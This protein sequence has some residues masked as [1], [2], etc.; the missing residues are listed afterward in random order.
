MHPGAIP[1]SARYL[2]HVDKEGNQLYRVT[3]MKSQIVDFIKVMKKNGFTC[4]D[5]FYDLA[6]Y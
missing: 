4:Q 5:F 2:D 1:G 6:A 3:C